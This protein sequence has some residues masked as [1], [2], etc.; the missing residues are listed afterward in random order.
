MENKQNDVFDFEIIADGE[1]GD[2]EYH[3][4]TVVIK[5]NQLAMNEWLQTDI[6]PYIYNTYEEWEAYKTRCIEKRKKWEKKVISQLELHRSKNTIVTVTQ[7]VNEIFTVVI[8][9]K[10]KGKTYKQTK[11]ITDEEGMDC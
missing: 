8:H 11:D 5:M 3:I 9:T 7:N 2:A 10:K 6:N 1:V 4:R